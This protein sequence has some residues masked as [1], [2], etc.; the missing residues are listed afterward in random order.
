VNYANPEFDKVL[1]TNMHTISYSDGILKIK[2]FKIFFN[3]KKNNKLKK[4]M[5]ETGSSS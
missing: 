4:N 2:V 3:K 1:K 5:N